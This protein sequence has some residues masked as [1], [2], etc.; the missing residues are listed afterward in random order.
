MIHEGKT[1]PEYNQTKLQ[2]PSLLRISWSVRLKETLWVNA[3]VL[4]EFCCEN[5]TGNDISS[6]QWTQWLGQYRISERE[7]KK[8]CSRQKKK[9]KNTHTLQHTSHVKA[10]FPP[11]QQQA[12]GSGLLQQGPDWVR[13]VQSQ[14]AWFGK[15]ELHMH[16]YL[17]PPEVMILGKKL[18]F[19]WTSFVFD[20]DAITLLQNDILG[21][22]DVFHRFNM[23]LIILFLCP[24]HIQFIRFAFILLF[25]VMLKTC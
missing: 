18:G 21:S 25:S 20:F 9:R 5:P 3:Q 1:Q 22:D 16:A 8:P 10:L 12:L 17:S 13:R 7:K 6:S 4:D 23:P 24:L 11:L 15:W 19:K 2:K 14:N